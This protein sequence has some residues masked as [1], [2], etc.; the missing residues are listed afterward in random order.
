M[1]E[2]TASSK[3][4]N[5]VIELSC[6]IP[7]LTDPSDY[8]TFDTDELSYLLLLLRL[9]V[10]D[11]QTYGQ[12]GSSF[13]FP[14]YSQI[15]SEAIRYVVTFGIDISHN[16]AEN[17]PTLDIITDF[18][19]IIGATIPLVGTIINI[20]RL[21]KAV[22]KSENIPTVKI[23]IGDVSVIVTY[24]DLDDAEHAATN[25]ARKLLK[26][27]PE[28]FPSKKVKVSGKLVEPAKPQKTP[29]SPKRKSRK[30]RTD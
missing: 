7:K 25:I 16:I 13:P 6:E 19:T 12:Y 2:E 5:T 4:R 21:D 14:D 23:S 9:D 24:E 10:R 11:L 1:F 28:A 8:S 20:L 22:H 15:F 18:A 17:K 30:G 29:T 26:E 27:H 3:P